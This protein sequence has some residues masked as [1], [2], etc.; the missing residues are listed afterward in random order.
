MPMLVAEPYTGGS[1]RHAVL[2]DGRAVTSYLEG[3]CEGLWERSRAPHMH[4]NAIPEEI[5]AM[6]IEAKL[7]HQRWGPKKVMDRRCQEYPEWRLPADS[8]AGDIE[9]AAFFCTTV[10]GGGLAMDEFQFDVVEGGE[11]PPPPVVSHASQ[12]SLR[13]PP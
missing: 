7:A 3:G 10:T 8:T 2:P 12:P 5:R 6:V 4:P 13:A 9:W 1:G 11:P